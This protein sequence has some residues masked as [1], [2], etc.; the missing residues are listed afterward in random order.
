MVE[1][2]G[3]K[4]A[5]IVKWVEIFIKRDEMDGG[6]LFSKINPWRRFNLG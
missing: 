5:W 3:F 1:I 2:K 6:D 4:L